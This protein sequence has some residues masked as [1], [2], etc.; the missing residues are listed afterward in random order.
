MYGME[1]TGL[2]TTYSMNGMNKQNTSSDKMMAT[3]LI[4]TAENMDIKDF[5][6]TKACNNDKCIPLH[7]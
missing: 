4:Y 6:W 7:N 1:Q 5:D 3:S 2:V